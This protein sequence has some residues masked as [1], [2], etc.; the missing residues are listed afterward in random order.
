MTATTLPRT[1]AVQTT[2]DRDRLIQGTLPY[3]AGAYGNEAAAYLESLGMSRDEILARAAQ[4]A[5]EA[6]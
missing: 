6:A 5:V 2:D 1:D 3:L 4:A